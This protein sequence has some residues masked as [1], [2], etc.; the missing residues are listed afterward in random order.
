MLNPIEEL[1]F[2]AIVDDF[3]KSYES[4]KKEEK[5]SEHE[6][7]CGGNCA[8]KNIVRCKDCVNY[9]SKSK[10]CK[11]LELFFEPEHFCSYAEKKTENIETITKEEY[12]TLSMLKALGCENI[13]MFVDLV[14][15]TSLSSTGKG[16]SVRLEE[17]R[18]KLDKKLFNKE[19]GR[20]I[21][22]LMKLEVI[23]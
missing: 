6:C 12:E 11:K 7:K 5:Q 15:N 3:S 18:F 10:T 17:N 2:Y 9:S 19:N 4:D 8:E 1:L 16:V 20:K 14:K 13:T 22:D 23:D 21:D